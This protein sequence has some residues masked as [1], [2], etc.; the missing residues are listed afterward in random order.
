M[1][2]PAQ[3]ITL[4]NRKEEEELKIEQEPARFPVL[5]SCNFCMYTLLKENVFSEPPQRLEHLKE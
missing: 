3:M 5:M 1:I 2:E 4:R